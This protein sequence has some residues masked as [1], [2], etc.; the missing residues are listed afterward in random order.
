MN[1]LHDRRFR[2]GAPPGARL[3]ALLCAGVCVGVC[4]AV[5][6][7]SAQE[8][9]STRVK[10]LAGDQWVK[11]AGDKGDK[12]DERGKPGNDA[13][14]KEAEKLLAAPLVTIVEKRHIAPGGDPH[15]Y[16]SIGI[17]WWPNPVTGGRPYVRRDGEVNPETR[18]YDHTRLTRFSHVVS[19]LALAFAQSGDARYAQRARE[20]LRAWFLDARTRMNPH[21]SHAQA[22]PG[23]NSGTPF[24]IIEGEALASRV[25][26]AILILKEGGELP[27][28][29]W[30]GIRAWFEALRGWYETSPHGKELDKE[31]HNIST[32]YDVQ[33]VSLALLLEDDA[34]ARRVVREA[35]V[36]RLGMISPKGELPAELRRA[37]SWDY[38][39][40]H[41]RALMRLAELGDAVGEDFWRASGPSG[42][43]IA[44]VLDFL[45]PYARG[46]KPWDYPQAGG[47]WKRQTIVPLLRKAATV[48]HDGRYEEAAELAAKAQ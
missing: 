1:S 26:A 6:S 34:G 12:G 44:R 29:E 27:E 20:W 47:T 19:R 2:F 37:K 15:D 17:Y 22:W 25:P 43:S 45:L 46:E 28:P 4:A 40:Y 41:L 48:Y 18:E 38:C 33:R 5:F 13:L 7:A 11:W 24:G 10:V 32:W 36:K 35:A 8:R 14:L 23:R 9:F 31:G 42:G 3:G 21:L 16:Y 30:E 39:C